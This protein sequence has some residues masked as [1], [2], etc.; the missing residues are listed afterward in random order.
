MAI[1]VDIMGINAEVTSKEQ[2]PT[3]THM[4]GK[5]Q[6]WRSGVDEWT[7]V[8][9]SYWSVDGLRLNSHLQTGILHYVKK[10]FV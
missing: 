10:D 1:A 7:A 2:F 6:G 3:F 5:I 9:N 4:K 8:V